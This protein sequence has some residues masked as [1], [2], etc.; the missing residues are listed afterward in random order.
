MKLWRFV[1]VPHPQVSAQKT[2]VLPSDFQGGIDGF[3]HSCQT[4]VKSSEMVLIAMSWW[5]YTQQTLSH[6]AVGDIMSCNLREEQREKSDF[7]CWCSLEP[8]GNLELFF[9]TVGIRAGKKDRKIAGKEGGKREERTEI[10]I[11]FFRLKMKS[12]NDEKNCREE[13]KREIRRMKMWWLLWNGLAAT[14]THTGFIWHRLNWT[15]SRSIRKNFIHMQLLRSD[16]PKPDVFFYWSLLQIKVLPGEY[17]DSRG[18]K[19]TKE[20][21]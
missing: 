1:Q 11:Y 18:R 15:K 6:A 12:D 21:N 5:F 3:Y 2:D 9:A 4:L 10:Y 20:W 19:N 17:P 16:G 7:M 13:G 14:H 8:W